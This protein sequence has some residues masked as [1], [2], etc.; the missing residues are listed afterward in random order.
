MIAHLEELESL[1][2]FIPLLETVPI[3]IPFFWAASS[4]MTSL[5]L[6]STIGL[7]SCS[8]SFLVLLV[9]WVKGTS[10]DRGAG[11]AGMWQGEDRGKLL[12]PAGAVGLATTG[13]NLGMGRKVGQNCGFILDPLMWVSLWRSW[14]QAIKRWRGKLTKGIKESLFYWCGYKHYNIQRIFASWIFHNIAAKF[15]SV[16]CDFN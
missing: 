1:F 7:P 13:T 14:L 5:K 4:K 6:L 9:A 8:R 10:G 12:K 16:W 11:N 2:L 15:Q 3:R